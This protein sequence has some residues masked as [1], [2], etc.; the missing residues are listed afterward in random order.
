VA[1]LAVDDVLVRATFVVIV[2][3]FALLAAGGAALADLPR[4]WAARLVVQ[5]RP[6]GPAAFHTAADRRVALAAF[7]AAWSGGA[8]LTVT[9]GEFATG[10]VATAAGG[11]TLV[12]AAEI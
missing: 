1:A 8:C 6:V 7:V 4:C 12:G 11:T 9:A 5:A 10:E 3:I 2:A